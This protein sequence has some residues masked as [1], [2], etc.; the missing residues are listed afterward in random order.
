[1]ASITALDYDPLSFDDVID[2]HQQKVSVI[3]TAW[4][5]PTKWRQTSLGGSPST[6]I[7]Q[8]SIQC[9]QDYYRPSCT[10]YCVRRDDDIV[11]HYTCDKASGHKVC[12]V[13]WNGVGCKVYCVPSATRTL[14]VRS[15]ALGSW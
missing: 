13:G 2:R 9:N 10:T 1:M 7:L 8:Y 12:R 14:H 11:G 4:V 5:S 3:S 6:T 15:G